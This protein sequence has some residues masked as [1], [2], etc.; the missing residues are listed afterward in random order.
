VKH[1]FF[2]DHDV[3]LCLPFITAALWG[4]GGSGL[5]L[6]RK[7]GV[8]AVLC[9][10]AYSYG[11]SGWQFAL[12]AGLTFGLIGFGPGYGDDFARRLK[13][14][15]WPY[16]FLLGFLYGFCQFPLALRFGS[17]VVLLQLSG[18]CSLVFGFGMVASKRFG[19]YWKIAECLT[20]LSIGAVASAILT[21]QTL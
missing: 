8:P 5:K 12:Y 1:F 15:Y 16:V 20:G 14:L 7:L 9:A 18:V 13:T 10:F 11:L 4:L 2:F 3:I 17:L 6:L 21:I 19:F